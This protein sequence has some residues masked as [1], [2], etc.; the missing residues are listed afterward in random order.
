MGRL[1]RDPEI[2]YTQ[3][4]NPMPVARFSL[5][6]NKIKPNSYGSTVDYINIVA[7]DRLATFTEKYLNK[8]IKI[9]LIGKANTGTYEKNGVK[10]PF[11]EVHADEIE[12]AESKSAGI[13]N[14]N[15]VEKSDNKSEDSGFIVVQD[16]LLDELPFI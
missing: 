8:G 7:F 14:V 12:F 9:L 16:Y 13:E 5:A 11:F 15:V 6:V 10:M 1:S 3:S 2:R 4:S